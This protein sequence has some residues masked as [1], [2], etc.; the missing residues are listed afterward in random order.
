M[1]KALTCFGGDI[2]SRILKLGKQ[3]MKNYDLPAKLDNVKEIEKPSSSLSRSNSAPW[4]NL[5]AKSEII[6]APTKD[7][8]ISKEQKLSSSIQVS[9]SI[10]N[11]V[12]KASSTNSI[13]EQV[14][15]AITGARSEE[16]LLRLERKR[17]QKQKQEEFKRKMT[18]K[19]FKNVDK[20]TSK[21]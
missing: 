15:F 3:K 17:R 18:E 9:K 20:Q 1:R 8:G 19:D 21:Y 4:S 16:E 2:E 7:V 5:G 11:Q 6:E 13:D 10:V 14:N 12:Q